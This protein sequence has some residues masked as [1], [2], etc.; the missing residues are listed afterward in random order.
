MK[1]YLKVMMSRW[2]EKKGK[3]LP[4]T[5]EIEVETEDGFLAV[6]IHPCNP[7][8]RKGRP[9]I[10]EEPI[11]VIAPGRLSGAAT[12]GHSRLPVYSLFSAMHAEREGAEDRMGFS[13]YMSEY[14][15]DDKAI[16]ERGVEKHERA[17]RGYM[18]SIIDRIVAIGMR[19]VRRPARKGALRGWWSDGQGNWW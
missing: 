14:A 7:V 10:E 6:C 11:V 8:P 13:E 18:R 12:I 16:R 2:D 9:F 1:Q 4:L 5:T 17:H 15:F 19:P 3:W